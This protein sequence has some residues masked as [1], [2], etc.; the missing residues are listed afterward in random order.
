MQ[1]KHRF[2]I[3]STAFAGI[4]ALSVVALRSNMTYM[5]RSTG[6]VQTTVSDEKTLFKTIVASN[7][8]TGLIGFELH[9]RHI[10]SASATETQY[11]VVM[12]S[13]DPNTDK[14][15]EYCADIIADLRQEAGNGN[16]TINVFDSFEAYTF[17]AD[18]LG[19]APDANGLLAQ[20]LVAT[21]QNT[22]QHDDWY[23]SVTYYPWNGGRLRET[24]SCN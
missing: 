13:L 11:N 19:A 23:C 1:H 12:H 2:L 21:Y 5:R 14:Y 16:I 8:D 20:H 7:P 6:T 18:T 22:L 3:R 4:L 24:V 10:H 15:K 17:Y 9:K